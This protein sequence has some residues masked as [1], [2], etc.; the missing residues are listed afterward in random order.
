MR[1]VIQRIQNAHVKVDGEIIGRSGAGLLIFLGIG[2]EDTEDDIKYIADKALGLRIF[3][4]ENDKM[5]LSVRDING[6]FL[7]ISQFTLYGDC[8]RGRRPSFDSAM[9]PK[10]AEMMYEK[11]VE[12]VKES[13]LHCETGRFGA[14]MKVEL[15]NDGPVTILLD[16]A[17]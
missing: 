4:D 5:N 3:S 6:E 17:K 10:E 16:S 1:A 12:Y 7:I 11:F 15:L 9:P 13:G 14:D 2:R 8:R